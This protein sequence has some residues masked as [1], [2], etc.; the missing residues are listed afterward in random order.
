MIKYL[1]KRF[2]SSLFTIWGV[3]TICFLILH[4]APGNPASIYIRPEINSEVVDNIR[5]Q[6][7]FDLPVW[8]QY[9]LWIKEFVFGNFGH[10]FSHHKPVSD[11]LLEAIPNTLQL[12]LIVLIVQYIIGIFIGTLMAV[13]KNKKVNIS[14]NT[15]LLFLYSMPGFWLSLIAILIFSLKLGWLPPSQMSSLIDVGG[16]FSIFWDRILH[17]ILPVS[18]LSIPFIVFTSRF[19]NN[20]MQEEL[21]KPY[22][23]NAKAYNIRTKKIVYYY[24]LKNSL[25]PL[26]TMFGLY[27][28]FLLGGAVITEYIF[29][30]PGIGRITIN[31]IYTYDYPLIMASNFIAALAVVLG[32]LISDILYLIID[33]RIKLSGSI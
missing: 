28:P 11:V 31:A 8:K 23:L 3:L 9:F 30:W 16:V 7:G 13:K 32:N 20:S 14:L 6:M 27:L 24:A 12:T 2:G 5:H 17:L 18:I 19:V 10:S 26:S 21:N 29:A 15:T 1:F 25:L 22:I 33:P 4:L